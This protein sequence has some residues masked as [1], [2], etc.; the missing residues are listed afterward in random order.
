MRIALDA[1]RLL[2]EEDPTW[3]Y[4][5]HSL[6]SALQDIDRDNEY[7]L[8]FNFFRERYAEILKRHSFNDN[9]NI[10]T[11][12]IPHAFFEYLFE[13]L[14]LPIESFLGRHDVFHGPVYA[15]FNNILGRSVVTVHDLIFLRMPEYVSPGW[16]EFAKKNTD[17]AIKKADAIITISKYSKSDIID[18][19]KVPEDRIR[20]IY[21]GVGSEYFPRTKGVDEVRAKYGIS[22]AYVLSVGAVEP[23]KNLLR[24]LEAFHN[25]REST[26]NTHKLVVAGV[27]R[28]GSEEVFRK[29]AELRLEKEVIFTG[30]VPGEDLPFLY[31]G[32]GL[33]V[34]PSLNE[35]FGLPVLEAM[36]CGT[37]VIASN[38]TSIPEVAG[39]AAL[40]VDPGNNGELT[41]AI[42]AVLSDN[43]LRDS[44]RNKGLERARLFSWER[45]ARETLALYNEVS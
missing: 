17:Y 13:D 22:G 3:P 43:A 21:N 16:V 20:V 41:D 25:L 12:R 19:Y 38:R 31:S 5:L 34:F 26:R 6:I 9:V 11:A 4:Y 23:R 15:C 37:P 29:V 27:R 30:R 1:R 36:A 14:H 32:A 8:L 24:L 42:E 40:L 44:L 18:V 39:D 33:F 35:G 45:T 10:K 7:T 2:H 28:F